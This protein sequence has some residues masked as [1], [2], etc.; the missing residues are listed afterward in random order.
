MKKYADNFARLAKEGSGKVEN[1]LTRSIGMRGL[2]FFDSYYENSSI[3]YEIN[4]YFETAHI[5]LEMIFRSF[6]KKRTDVYIS[7]NPIIKSRLDG[8]RTENGE[9]CFEIS[10]E[11]HGD[12]RKINMKRFIDIDKIAKIRQEYRSIA[13]LKDE[14][15]Q[16][17]LCEF[18]GIKKHHF[19]LERI[20][21]SA[22]NF[23]AKEKFTEEFCNKIF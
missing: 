2:S 6:L 3:Y 22:M 19:I 5:L 15:L 17:A 8:I 10:D 12:S 9:I 20:Y 1:R 11:D 13:R 16:M 7:N 23:E 4:D 14:I 18:E 21:G